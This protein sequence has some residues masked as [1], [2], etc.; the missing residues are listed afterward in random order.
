MGVTKA[1]QVEVP[2]DPK[3]VG[4]YRFSP[5]P[6]ASS[7]S[8]VVVGHVDSKGRGLGVLAALNNVR[9]GDIVRV[10]R[11]AGRPVDFRVVSRRTVA[12]DAVDAAGAFRVQGPA[13]LTVITCTGPYVASEGGYQNN[14][15]V[16]AEPVNR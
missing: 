3:R 15:V 13:V 12:K 5:A 11:S 2:A 1:G 6:G 8:S 7:G 9:R 10:T 4:W 16:T 14:L